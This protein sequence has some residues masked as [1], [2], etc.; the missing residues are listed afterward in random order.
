M[1]YLGSKGQAGVWQRIISNM[2]PHSFYVEPF[3]GSGQIFRRKL[4]AA[5]SVLIDA[6]GSVFDALSE[7]ERG[8]AQVMVGDALAI[9][10]NLKLPA[11]AVVYCD[12]PY[13]HSTRTSRHGYKFEM[14][15]DRHASLLA[16]LQALPCRVMISGYP[17]ELY[18]A[19]LKDW[20]CIAY[21]T[22]TRG[23]TLTECLWCNFPE[24]TRLHDW[25]FAGNNFRDRT[26]LKRLAARFTAR[27]DR[28]PPLQRNYL[29]DLLDQRYL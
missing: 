25:R 23:R 18:A 10:P 8:S 16:L 27:L 1:G 5:A 4:P 15:D 12:P 13:V 24:P 28:M 11:D 7:S 3:F 9:L 6:D 14:T 29:L 2:P 22:R 17:C 19:A 20:R 26:R 21:R